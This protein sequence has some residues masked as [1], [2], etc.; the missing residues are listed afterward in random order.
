VPRDGL[1]MDSSGNLYGTTEFGGKYNKGIVFKFIP[2]ANK[3]KYTEHI[4][5]SL[6]KKAGCPFGAYPDSDLIT[7]VDGNLYGTTEGGGAHTEGAVFKMRPVANGWVISVIH[8]FCGQ[9]PDCPDGGVPAGRLAYAGQSSG[10]AWDETSPLF[11]TANTGGSSTSF[12]PM[13]RIGISRC[14]TV[15][16]PPP[17]SPTPVHSWWTRPEISSA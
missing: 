16:I 1:L 4:L 17:I 15:S 6:C 2:N 12:R 9:P 5:W 13:V 14:F 3:T 10:A 11:G 8:S 7:D